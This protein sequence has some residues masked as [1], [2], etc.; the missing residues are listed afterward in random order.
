M[1][2]TTIAGNTTSLI[3]SYISTPFGFSLIPGGSQR[4]QLH[5]RKSSQNATIN[6]FARLKLADS[7]GTVLATIG[8]TGTSQITWDA[9]NPVEVYVDITLPSTQVDPTNRMLV[10]LYAIN[11]DANSHDVYFYTEG[12]TNYSYVV[13]TLSPLEGQ[14]GATGPTGP[15]GA[16][17][18]TGANGTNGTN[19]A[20]GATG[21]T[22][23]TGATGATGAASTVT[24]PTG[25]TGATGPTGATGTYSN[26]DITLNGVL[27]IETVNEKIITNNA[28]TG[29]TACDFSS[30][31]IF[32]YTNIAG[33]ITMNLTNFSLASNTATNVTNVL[34]Q[35]ATA[36][37]VTAL[38]I[39]GVAQTINWQAG[40]IPSGN[41]SKKDVV[42]F[43]IYNISGTY[44]TFGQLVTFG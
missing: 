5:L 38:Q 8:D 14:A 23:P 17:G 7:S 24:G 36:Y 19:G 1:L 20:T 15:T 26:G 35:G 18:A 25:A 6:V 27:T 29:V 4:F 34:N 41:A 10:E 13:T 39:G 40:I 28:S 21:A 43:T 32:N 3:D 11:E 37:M 30:A 44:M 31:G 9:A 12:P 33:N 2:T 22:G 42:M 16:T